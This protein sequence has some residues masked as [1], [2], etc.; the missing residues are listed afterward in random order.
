MSYFLPSFLASFKPAKPPPTI[1]TFIK[2]I[3]AQ[4]KH[5][6]YSANAIAVHSILQY[7]SKN[8]KA[9]CLPAISH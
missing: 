3:L 8:N 2:N 5:N 9:K 7:L 4:N 6:Y 1:T